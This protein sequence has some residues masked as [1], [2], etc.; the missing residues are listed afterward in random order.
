MGTQRA[1]RRFLTLSP[2]AAWPMP[3]SRRR[4][5]TIVC[6]AVAGLLLIA[7]VIAWQNRSSIALHYGQ[8]ALVDLEFHEADE[9]ARDLLAQRPDWP[10]A[11]LLSARAAAGCR[12]TSRALELYTRYPDTR[13][14]DALSARV[15]AGDLLMERLHKMSAAEAEYRRVLKHDPTHRIANDRIAYL[16]SAASRRWEAISPR[17]TICRQDSF[18]PLHLKILAVGEGSIVEP[19]IVERFH[20][21]DPDDPAPLISMAWLALGDQDLAYAEDLLQDSVDLAPDLAEAQA[22][23]A[24]VLLR[25]GNNRGFL[26]WYTQL[27]ESSRQH[28]G[29]WS[30]MGRFAAARHQPEMA[31]RCFWEAVRRDPNHHH[32]NYQLGQI[33]TQLGREPDAE[34]FLKRSRKINRYTTRVPTAWASERLT[35]LREVAE[36]AEDL[37]LIWE[38]YGW[39]LWAQQKGIE[40]ETAQ[41][42]ATDMVSRLAPRLD[43]L[44]PVR[45]IA[46]AN[47]A[48]QIDLGFLPLPDWDASSSSLAARTVATD[49]RVSF[50]DQA[51][52]TGLTFSYN[53]G[54]DPS[55]DGPGHM[56]EMTGGGAAAVDF[57]QD[58]W[59]DLFLPQGGVF[60][61]RGKQTRQIDRLFRNSGHGFEDVT[62]QAGLHSNGFGQ[63]ATVGDVNGDGFPDILVANIGGNRLWI[64]NGDGTFSDHSLIAGISGKR[65]TTSCLLVDLNGDGLPDLYE[66]NFLSGDDVYTRECNKIGSPHQAE[67]LSKE[68]RGQS[69][70]MRAGI[71]TPL[72]F[73][74]SQDQLFLNTGDG[75][76]RNVTSRCGIQVPHGNGL[77]IVAADFSG[78]GTL[79]LFLANDS[80]PNFYFVHE[81]VDDTG[82][83]RFQERALPLGIA[84]N[85]AGRA[86]ACMGVA[87]GDADGDG[88]LDLYV[89]NFLNQSNTLYR[90]LPQ[91]EFFADITQRSGLHENS[92]GLLGWG[93]Q[94]VDADLDGQLDLVVTNGH[95]EDFPDKQ[96]LYE[97]PAQYLHNTGGGRF[98]QLP[99][100]Q[101]GAFFDKHVL[102]RGMARL[103]WNRDGLNDVV[104]S[105]MDAPVAL[106]T[107]TTPQPGHHVAI[108]LRATQSARDAIGTRLTLTVGDKTLY[109]QQT[110][111]DGYMASNHR[112]VIFG[113]GEATRVGPLTVHWPSGRVDTFPSLPV[114]GE[115]MLIEGRTP[116]RIPR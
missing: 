77:G 4:L 7:G 71:C 88:R 90:K 45:T 34:P 38:A 107:C 15:E 39:S 113:T 33:L 80:V 85:Q 24:S 23:L 16:L 40:E 106:L 99:P 81:G 61:E 44:K 82:V 66:A 109:R 59:P 103:D 102:G 55:H 116:S 46:S 89:T 108:R 36:L 56:F 51:A 58:G 54:G 43:Q 3:T 48:T 112:Q 78:T 11:I 32:A 60:D 10:D 64:N 8:Q 111:G 114:D 25:A 68:S 22:L 12:D 6:G 19:R 14:P 94:F 110:A 20:S 49:V 28:P 69:R 29:V 72:D 92:M 57:D 26:E 13:A 21:G 98:V 84:V 63:G 75:Q 97:M 47:P 5:T 2:P 76:F 87:T 74:A 100:S 50:E 83:P 62:V 65:W 86:E 105:H 79:S 73:P 35:E 101:V 115:L 96:T 17:I 93:T 37:G 27:P 67:T 91:R 31:A 41:P 30:A 53:N 104:I 18:N 9:W 52:S 70:T 42:W 1:V 95:V